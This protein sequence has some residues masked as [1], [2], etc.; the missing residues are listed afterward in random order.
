MRTIANEDAT[1]GAAVTAATPA[2]VE[3]SLDLQD[4]LLIGGIASSLAGCV[5]I[6]WPAALILASV[7]CFAG[8]YMIERSKG[9]IGSP[10]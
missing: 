1:A 10:K 2:K 8:V 6:W 7:Y 5:V 9:T 3:S 4:W